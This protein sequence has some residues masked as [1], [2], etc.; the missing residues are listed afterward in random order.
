MLANSTRKASR[1]SRI[2]AVDGPH[3]STSAAAVAAQTDAR[4]VAVSRCDPRSL[5][6]FETAL[7]QFQSYFGDPVETMTKTLERDPE[8]VLG[9]I[10]CANAMLLMSERQYLP[11]IRQCID[12]AKAL[13]GKANERESALL[14]AV[15]H[16]LTG[17]WD[18]AATV[19]D[20]VLVDNPCDSLTLQTAHLM[21]FYQG[22]ALNLRDRISRVLG[23]WDTGMPGYSYV[24]GLQAF[25]FE[26]CNEFELAEQY[27]N[28]ALEIERRDPWSV[29]A[30]THVMEMQNRFEE[31]RDFLIS[32]ADDWAPDN[33]FA[34]HNWWH[35]GLFFLEQ[36]DYASALQ[37]YDE[38]ITPR[39][40]DIALELVDASALLWRLGLMGQDVADRWSAVADLWARK[41]SQENGYY[42]FNDLHA[43][44]AFVGA[45]NLAAAREV[46]DSV[47]AAA[48]ENPGVT[49]TMARKVGVPACT[50]MIAFGEGR[51]DD[52]IEQ[53]YPLRSI[54]PCFGGSN[55][56][57]DVLTQTLL[58][59]AIRAGNTR[60]ASNLVN[61]RNV[62]KPFSPLTRRF[63]SRSMSRYENA[64]KFS[65]DR[66]FET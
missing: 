8:F 54:A 17:A 21:D 5:Q 51:Y 38:H 10:F 64:D 49:R 27:A 33:G 35:L 25:G 23:H 42:A 57:R 44:M 47:V 1:H 9:H 61:E 28:R 59:S 6:D 65:A 58:E 60:L 62:H 19:W 40:S 53:L 43:V 2:A 34:F 4:G 31:G 29:H 24:L 39:D 7:V 12:R 46:L 32:R 50:A 13:S 41:T 11:A 30:L 48:R 37:L 22:D 55:A 3:S 45:G 36:E 20:R 52:A 15:E 26:E 16:M 63:A 18:S 56:Q 66:G 14:T